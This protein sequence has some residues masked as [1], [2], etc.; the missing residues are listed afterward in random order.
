M[1]G[2]NVWPVAYGTRPGLPLW[3][4]LVAAFRGAAGHQ[5]GD[6]LVLRWANALAHLHRTRVINP[7]RRTRI[8]TRR[9]ELRALIDGWVVVHVQPRQPWCQSTGYGG[10]VDDMAAARTLPLS[11]SWWPTTRPTNFI[12]RGHTSDT[13]PFVGPTW[14]PRPS[15]VSARSRH[16]RPVMTALGGAPND[17]AAP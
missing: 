6:H 2:N 12:E 9:R 15:T 11:S 7:R 10:V 14:S 5:P 3:R 1:S 17:S 4:E 8:D 16:D 13:W